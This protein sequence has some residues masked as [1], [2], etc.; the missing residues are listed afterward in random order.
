MKEAGP[1][2]LNLR[3]LVWR[4]KLGSMCIYLPEDNNFCISPVI[5]VLEMVQKHNIYTLL[6]IKYINSKDLLYST[7]NYTQYFLTTYKEKIWKEY[8]RL[9]QNHCNWVQA[10]S[11]N[12]TFTKKWWNPPDQDQT[13]LPHPSYSSVPTPANLKKE[14]GQK[15]W[16]S[17]SSALRNCKV[18]EMRLSFLRGR[19]STEGNLW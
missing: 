9:N 11:P 5:F 1:S 16:S 4:G 12:T 7:G 6:H 10:S 17:E 8:Q 13:S 18:H 2:S 19:Q 14:L 15:K 3:I